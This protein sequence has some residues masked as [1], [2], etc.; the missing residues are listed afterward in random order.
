MQ[1]YPAP[2]VQGCVCLQVLWAPV[3]D[4]LGKYNLFLLG[5]AFFV[6]SSRIHIIYFG[7]FA[8]A[9]H[10]SV[11][12]Q[13]AQVTLLCSNTD[14]GG[15]HRAP[16][17]FRPGMCPFAN[18]AQSSRDAPMWFFQES[19]CR[20]RTFTWSNNWGREYKEG[21]K[22]LSLASHSGRIDLLSPLLAWFRL[23]WND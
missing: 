19:P 8:A 12:M 3:P 18:M 2:G 10:L 4:K 17:S 5:N 15:A 23:H 13:K 14:Y 11:C 9:A 20:R 16:A 21:R 7:F 22:I 1:H 6:H